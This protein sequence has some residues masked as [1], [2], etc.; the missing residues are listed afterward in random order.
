MQLDLTKTIQENLYLLLNTRNVSGTPFAPTNVTVGV[1]DA[2]TDPQDV[3]PHN[4]KITVTGLPGHWSSTAEEHYTRIDLSTTGAGIQYQLIEGTTVAD[5]KAALL[6]EL[7]L[8]A[9]EVDL[10]VTEV[11][12]IPD[13]DPSVVIN[14]VAK[15][16]S[17]AY[18]GSIPVTLLRVVDPPLADAFTSSELDGFEQPA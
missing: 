1:P 8:L 16:Q 18:I 10:S 14:L 9:S 13:E 15:P 11:P 4:T 12:A 3:S 6:T 5:I 17:Y 7:K 2:W